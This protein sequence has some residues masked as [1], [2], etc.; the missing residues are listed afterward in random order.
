LALPPLRVRLDLG[1][2][3]PEVLR[4]LW[5]EAEAV[6]GPT[7]TDLIRHAQRF[8]I[9]GVYE[10]AAQDGLDKRGLALLRVELD[11]IEAACKNGRYTVGKRRRRG[12]D[13]TREMIIALRAR[14]LVDRA[15]AT[16]LGISYERVRKLGRDLPKP[17]SQT[18]M[19]ERQ[20]SARNESP[21]GRLAEVA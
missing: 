17:G 14:G 12:P 18:R 21:V 7:L 3:G 19:V 10:T 4:S 1:D 11:R 13:E 20:K 5:Q 2:R 6:N 9:D 15:I 16:K 8:G